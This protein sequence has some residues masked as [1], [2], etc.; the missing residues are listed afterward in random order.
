MSKARKA[1]PAP[2]T[3]AADDVL[4]EGDM[5]EV[6]RVAVREAKAGNMQAT[7]IVERMHRR[8]RRTVPLDLPPV[9]DAAGLAAA[10]SEVIAAAARGLITPHE[11]IAYAT[12]LEY[13]R[14][15]LDTVEYEARLMEIEETN[16]E[17]ARREAATK[18][19]ERG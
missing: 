8:R 7:A 5:A 15:A 18:D 16:A 13:R 11:G 1:K 10:Q 6:Q 12:M 2:T 19:G 4:S 3:T 9:D 14:R 17:R